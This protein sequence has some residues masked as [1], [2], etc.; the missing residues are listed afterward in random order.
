[1]KSVISFPS[2][3]ESPEKVYPRCI[4]LN[5]IPPEMSYSTL[6]DH[7]PTHYSRAIEN[8][9]DVVHLP[10]IHHNTIGRGN[11]AVV[12]GPIAEFADDFRLAQPVGL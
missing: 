9:L 6:R 2:G 4:S 11:R 3:G 8:Q 10:F 12:D 1:M 7:W 5:S